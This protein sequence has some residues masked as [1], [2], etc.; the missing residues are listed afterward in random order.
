MR[1]PQNFV[2]PEGITIRHTKREGEEIPWGWAVSYRDFDT[3]RGICYPIPLHLLVRWQR[4]IRF[5]LMRVGRPSYRERIEHAAWLKG[6]RAGEAMVNGM[7]ANAYAKGLA[8]GE[9]QF[10]E[11]ALAELRNGRTA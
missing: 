7:C 11:R 1:L 6:R 2:L 8:D 4:D 9:A 10:I 3:D 5:W